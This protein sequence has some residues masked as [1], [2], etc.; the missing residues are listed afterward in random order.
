VST[1]KWVGEREIVRDC[2]VREIFERETR[3]QTDRQTER[4][5]QSD[6]KRQSVRQIDRDEQSENLHQR[7]TIERARA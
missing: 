4:D 3:R 5:S 1:Q 2:F 6:R 7:E